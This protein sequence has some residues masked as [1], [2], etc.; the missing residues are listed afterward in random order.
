MNQLEPIIKNLDIGSLIATK[1]VSG[2]SINDAF[3]VETNKGEFFLKLNSFSRFPGM[4]EA[5]NRG[6][7]LLSQSSFTIPKP[8]QS[9]TQGGTQFF[10]MEWMEQGIP[11]EGFW[12]EFGRALGELHLISSEHFGLDHDNYIGS[13]RQRNGERKTWDEFYRDE[14][15]IP[16]L[17]LAQSG[18]KSTAKMQRGFEALFVE[19]ENLFPKENQAF[20]MVIYGVGT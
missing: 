11:K 9:G 12:D 15:L 18:G 8:L 5:E 7:E 16:Q 1:S 17:N 19:M 6:L 10:L 2:G 3:Q 20:C 13:L 14:R 4:F